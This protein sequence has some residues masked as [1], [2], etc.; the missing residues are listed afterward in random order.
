MEN[1]KISRIAQ[2]KKNNTW[3]NS[4]EEYDETAVYKSLS[5]DLIAKK[6]NQCKYIKNIKRVQNYNGFIT[7]IVTYDNN[8][9]SVYTVKEY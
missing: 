5:R 9:R 1:N 7:V 3:V 2:T 4:F 8:T 6:I